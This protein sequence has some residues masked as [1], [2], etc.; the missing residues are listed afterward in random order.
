MLRNFGFLFFQVVHYSIAGRS[1]YRSFRAKRR[2]PV[3]TPATENTRVRPF[4]LVTMNLKVFGFTYLQK[5]N[6]NRPL[7]IEVEL[8]P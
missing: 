1:V 5:H 7:S 6:H 4:A 2:S 3:G 8:A